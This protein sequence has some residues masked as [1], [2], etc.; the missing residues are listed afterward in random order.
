M[1]WPDFFL[2]L[3]K[4]SAGCQSLRLSASWALLI[5]ANN[6]QDVWGLQPRA[7]YGSDS[8]LGTPTGLPS[9]PARPR[10]KEFSLLAPAASSAT[11]SKFSLSIS[12][13]AAA[14]DLHPSRVKRAAAQATPNRWRRQPACP[15]RCGLAPV[16]VFQTS[17]LVVTLP[18]LDRVGFGDQ[19]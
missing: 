13:R 19:R 3:H 14:D 16:E 11:L 7:S 10:R 4:K 17:S 1:L 6:I 9:R 12:V 2:D 8:Q 15:R 5:A 18:F